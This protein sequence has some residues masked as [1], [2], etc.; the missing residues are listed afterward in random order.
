MRFSIKTTNLELTS[1]LQ[2]YIEKKINSLDRFIENLNSAVQAWVEI[3]LTTRHHQTGKVYRAEIQIHL[4][5]KSVRAEAVTKNI[6]AS[7]NEAIDELQR[8]LK[9]YKGK[10]AEEQERASRTLK[11]ILKG[12]WWKK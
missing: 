11:D 4:P 1:E 12:A 8:E 10:K 9:K 5:G 2:D 3:G 6:F 7:F